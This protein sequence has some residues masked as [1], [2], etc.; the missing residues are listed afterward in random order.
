MRKT[1][2]MKP[3]TIAHQQP[4]AFSRL[5]KRR[6]RRPRKWAAQVALDLLQVLVEAVGPL[7]HRDPRQGDDHHHRCGGAARLT[8]CCCVALGFHFS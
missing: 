7:D 5:K 6:R 2:M 3:A 4:L 1:P 8:I